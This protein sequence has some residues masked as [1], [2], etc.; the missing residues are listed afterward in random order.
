MDSLVHVVGLVHVVCLF[1]CVVCVLNE[2]L[3]TSF[4]F[5]VRPKP[6]AGPWLQYG[7]KRRSPSE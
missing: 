6:T 4:V 2:V 5:V 3:M 1:V 7:K